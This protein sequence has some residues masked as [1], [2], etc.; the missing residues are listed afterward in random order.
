MAEGA[1][2]SPWMGFVNSIGHP[3]LGPDHLQ[4][5]FLVGFLKLM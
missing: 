1:E 2:L 3:L 5:L 4:F